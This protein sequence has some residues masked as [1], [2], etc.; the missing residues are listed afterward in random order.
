MACV[1]IV[2]DGLERWRV[3]DRVSL[4]TP[5]KFAAKKGNIYIYI[6]RHNISDSLS[7]SEKVRHDSNVWKRFERFTLKY[8]SDQC[9]ISSSVESVREMLFLFNFSLVT[10]QVCFKNSWAGTEPH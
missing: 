7:L 6:Y 3:G 5:R 4:Y 2:M 10:G 9:L 8:V 1:Y